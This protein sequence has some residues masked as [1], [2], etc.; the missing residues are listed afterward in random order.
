M[1]KGD[2]AI[3]LEGVGLAFPMAQSALGS[4]YWALE[5]IDLELKHGDKLG[6]IG[7]NGAGKSTL[8]RVLAGSMVPDRGKLQRNHDSVQLLSLG[9]GFVPHLTGR[10]NAI[11]SA[12]L[13]GFNRR[14]IEAK[15]DAVKEFSGLGGFF[16]EP[17]HTYSSGMTSRLGFSLAMQFEPQ[18]LL[19]DE[20]LSVGDAEF[21]RK[22]KDALLRRFQE[23]HTIVLVSHSEAVVSSLCTTALWVEHGRSV[24]SGP[25]DEVLEAYAAAGSSA[26]ASSDTVRG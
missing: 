26:A 6:V 21:N 16:E 2:W 18:I 14:E 3:R 12:L 24:M 17:I 11:L 8:L 10:D 13:Q 20:T 5:H 22:S 7:R 23:E 1:S 4:K 19:L 9:V 15:L 25:V